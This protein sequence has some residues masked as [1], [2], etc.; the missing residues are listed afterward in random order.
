VNSIDNVDKADEPVVSGRR[1]RISPAS[2]LRTVLAPRRV[3]FLAMGRIELSKWFV[4]L[5]VL[6]SQCSFALPAQQA[7]PLLASLRGLA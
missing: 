4:G 5:L 1:E 2:W 7:D 6:T 3:V